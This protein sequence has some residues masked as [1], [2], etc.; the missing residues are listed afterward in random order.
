MK[1]VSVRAL[2]LRTSAIL[3]EVEKGETVIVERKGV[4][5]A[6]LRPVHDA[7]G[8]PLPNR[9]AFLS[10]LPELPDTATILEE[11]RS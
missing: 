7:P 3:A 8:R 2:H 4:A 5:I 6:T 1:R 9:D 10:Q 11:I